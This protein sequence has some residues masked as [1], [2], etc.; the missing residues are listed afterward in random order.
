MRLGKRLIGVLVGLGAAVFPSAAYATFPGQNGKFVFTRDINVW[1]MNADGTGQTQLTS[2]RRDAHPVWSPDGTMI[3]FSRVLDDPG[4]FRGAQSDIFTMRADGTE[5][6]NLTNTTEYE[7]FPVWS[8]DGSRIAFDLQIGFCFA[9]FCD[10]EF[11]DLFAMSS[12]GTGRTRLTNQNGLDEVFPE[13]SPDGS[14]IVFADRGLY[15]VQVDGSGV[16]Q[17]TDGPDAAPSWS[18]DGSKIAFESRRDEFGINCGL[19]CNTN[20]YVANADG[21]GVT[22]LTD[23]PAR[24]EWPAWS[25]DGTK[26]AF[27]RVFC[28]GSTCSGSDIYVMNADGSEET[29]VTTGPAFEL[30]PDWQPLPNR[31]PDCSSVSVSPIA[32]S[33]PNHKFVTATLSGATDPDGD[34]VTLAITGVTQ[35]EPTGGAPDAAAG[36]APNQVRLRAERD[37]GGNGRMYRVAFEASDGKGGTCNGTAIAGVRKGGAA[38]VDSAPPS[39]DSF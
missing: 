25:P 4:A 29:Q 8:P 10:P 35:D 24:D 20:I 22:R 19:A 11:D 23:H 31:R 27:T 3:A 14:K 16:S 12:D 18:P 2:S 30:F 26:I 37:G 28:D 33:P 39:F 5:E 36:T 34:Q 32:L 1:T 38:P 13:W 15:A 7:S 6:R 17:L 9:G 21:S